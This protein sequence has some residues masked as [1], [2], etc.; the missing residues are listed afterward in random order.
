MT[1]K[2]IADSAA[3]LSQSVIEEYNIDVLP[4]VVSSDSEEFYDG[5]TIYPKELFDEMKKG[6]VYKTAQVPPQRFEKLFTEYAGNNESC[7][8]I[9]FSSE[10]SGTYQTAVMIENQVKEEYPD[11]DLEIIDSKCA[12]V[13]LGLV[14][15][16]AA[17]M[18]RQERDKKEIVDAVEFYAEHMEHIFTVDDLEY[19]CRGGRV[20]RTAAFV[21]ELFNIKPILDVEDGKLVPIEKARG[22]KRVLKRIIE[23]MEERGANL[24]EQTIGI[25]HGDDSEGADK[26][27]SMIEERFGTEEFFINIIGGVIGAHAGP[28]TLSVFFL[29]E[30]YKK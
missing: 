15:L 12:S 2:I 11:F 16:K 5:E 22:R 1:V 21:G 14:V 10:L 9:A 26:L 7:I 23:L 29:N 8:Y 27:K 17:E 20:N 18:A 4:L 30:E 6:R 25:C 28:G 19:L 3:D 13:G 24:S